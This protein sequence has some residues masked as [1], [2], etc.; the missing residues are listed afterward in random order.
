MAPL[1]VRGLV[2]ASAVALLAAAPAAARVRIDAKPRLEPRFSES[3]SDYVSRCGKGHP[4]R[5]EV[6]AGD[7]RVSVDGR[8]AHSGRFSAEVDLRSGQS[9]RLDVASGGRTRRHYVRCLPRRFPR[10]SYSRHGKPGAQWYL[11]A[12][13]GTSVPLAVTHSVIVFDR[14]GVPV[15]WRRE[16]D[17]PFNSTLLAEGTIAWT[18]WYGGPFGMRDEGAWEFHRLDGTLVRTLRTVDSPTDHHDMEQLPNGNFLLDAY[19]LRHNVDLSRYGGHGVGNVSD[20]EI[21]ELTPSGKLVWT[22]SSK[23]HVRPSETDWPPPLRS[24]PDGESAF[25][26]FHLNSMEPDRHGGLI[27]S[28]RHTN[29]VYRIDMATGK[30]TWKLGGTKRPQSLKVV[31]DPRKP[32]FRRQHDV[33]LAPDG[34]LTVFDNRSE[35]GAPRAVRFRIDPQDRTARFV[36]EATE[37]KAPESPAEGSARKLPDGHWVV[38]WGA[39]KVMS[40]LTASGRL[41]W[42]LLLRDADVSTYRLTPVPFGRLGAFELRRAMDRMH[43]RTP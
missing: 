11:T 31:G 25:D 8:H 15:W 35:I 29:A 21:Q 10:W 9:A 43:P 12:P 22:W 4:L 33:R 40:E 17:E 19:R 27:V 20:G 7:A 24:V 16:P 23:D 5:L 30:V 6:D 13:A 37:E 2:A 1:A 41:V 18:R 38:A 39:T 34:S 3:V 26:V 14:H 32:T 42:R 36:E 28:A